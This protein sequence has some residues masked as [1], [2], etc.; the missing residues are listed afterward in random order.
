MRKRFVV[1]WIAGLLLCGSALLEGS[2]ISNP[3][4]AYSHTVDGQFTG[5]TPTATTFEWFDITPV[6]GQYSKL[7]YDYVDNLSMSRFFVMNDWFVNTESNPT[8]YPGDYNQFLITAG[9]DLYEIRVYGNGSLTLTKNGLA[10][11]TYYEGGFFF[12]TSPNSSTA[13]TMWEIA[14]NL[15]P[16]TIIE[17]PNDPPSGGAPVTPDPAMPQGTTVAL[18]Q[19]GGTTANIIPEPATWWF[20]PIGLALF[21]IGA[22]SRRR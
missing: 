22:R 6:V 19:G 14:I 4:S 7:Y 2:P 11:S 8:T 13:H 17:D 5:W 20:A 1:E 10:D 16:G 12:G 15:P 3:V 21:A 18:H 9:S